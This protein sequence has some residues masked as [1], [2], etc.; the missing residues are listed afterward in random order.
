MTG[1]IRTAGI[2]SFVPFTVERILDA[3]HTL[4]TAH[5]PHRAV[6][7]LEMTTGMEAPGARCK[8]WQR[9]LFFLRSFRLQELASKSGGSRSTFQEETLQQTC[10]IITM[11]TLKTGLTQ[12]GPSHDDQACAREGGTQT[13]EPFF[14]SPCSPLP[15]E[16]L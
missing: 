16:S 13:G 12:A 14:F 7:E 3:Q 4:S 9:F 1:Y 15:P 2:G 6:A 5:E 10:R 11:T 8:Q